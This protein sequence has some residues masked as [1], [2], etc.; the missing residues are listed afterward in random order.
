MIAH[1]TALLTV[2]LLS[3]GQLMLKKLALAASG[4]FGGAGQG[5]L[6][7]LSAALAFVVL[8]Y[9]AAIVMWLFV[10]TRIPLTTA[11]LYVGLT[12]VFVPMFAYLEGGEQIRLS[13]IIGS[14]LIVLGVVVANRF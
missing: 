12:F 7:S 2:L 6:G 10:L 4:F 9:G 5:D 3:F 8:I 14:S 13:T 11:F 1:L